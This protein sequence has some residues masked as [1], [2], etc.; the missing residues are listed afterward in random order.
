MPTLSEVAPVLSQVIDQKQAEAMATPDAGALS[1]PAPVTDITTLGAKKKAALLLWLKWHRAAHIPHAVAEVQNVLN[2]T[3][4]PTVQQVVEFLR[5]SPRQLCAKL[6]LS[7]P[8]LQNLIEEMGKIRAEVA[9]GEDKWQPVA[10]TPTVKEVLCDVPNKD[11]VTIR[12]TDFDSRPPK[13]TAVRFTRKDTGSVVRTQPEIEAAG[14]KVTPTEIV[15]P[16]GLL[17]AGG[18]QAGDVVQVRGDGLD[19]AGYTVVAVGG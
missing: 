3:H 9:R 13:V 15:V 6:N 1:G 4:P 10:V 19:S 8:V 11:D 12:G 16:A 18:V 7:L 2:M 17:P 14:G 5:M